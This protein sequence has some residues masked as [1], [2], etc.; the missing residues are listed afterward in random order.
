MNENIRLL[1]LFDLSLNSVNSIK[2]T[3][4]IDPKNQFQTM[5][6]PL[7]FHLHIQ[8]ASIL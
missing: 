8:K 1:I 6:H 4:S 3:N 7:D 5:D 2:S